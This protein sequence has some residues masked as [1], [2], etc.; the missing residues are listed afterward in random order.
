MRVLRDVLDPV[1]LPPLIMAISTGLIDLIPGYLL[2]VSAGFISSIPLLLFIYPQLLSMRGTIGGIFSGRLSTSLHLGEIKPQF[3]DNTT[4]FYTLLSV[5]STLYLIAASIITF[6]SLIFFIFVYS[7]DFSRMLNIVLHIFSTFSLSQLATIPVSLIIAK[8][9]Y[10]RGWDPDVITYPF[11]S[12]FGDLFITVFYLVVGHLIYVFD[13]SILA[14]IF[15]VPIIVLPIVL[16]RLGMDKRLFYRELGESIVSLFISGLIVTVTGYIMQSFEG[17]IRSRPYIYFIYPALLTTIGDV[18]SIIGSSST[19]GLS[20]SGDI[21]HNY[22]PLI[23]MSILVVVIP[24]LFMFYTFLGHMLIVGLTPLVYIEYIGVGLAG[25]M[26]T[27]LISLFS[28]SI[29]YLTFR[30][31]LDPDHFVIPIEST[32][33][34]L[35]TTFILYIVLISI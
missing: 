5:V 23:Y 7:I 11:T 6:F 27:L 26:S 31:S 17:Y 30:R 22:R 1:L 8:V 34:D 28:I 9:S 14:I 16:I 33:A 25:F 15:T 2:S 32:S 19:T 29:A 35:L 12:S 13:L 10:T 4:V 18:G 24:I 20:M 3:S 21:F